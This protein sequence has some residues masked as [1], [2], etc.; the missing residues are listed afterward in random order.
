MLSVQMCSNV[1]VADFLREDML[2]TVELESFEIVH[3]NRTIEDALPL[4]FF[5]DSSQEKSLVPIYVRNVITGAEREVSSTDDNTDTPWQDDKLNVS[6]TGEQ[7][8]HV[9]RW[10][11]QHGKI[12]KDLLTESFHAPQDDV[13]VLISGPRKFVVDVCQP[14]V[15]EMGYK[16]VI[17]MW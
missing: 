17:A 1:S 13:L 15:S 5:E 14:L 16:N 11:V 9:P 12:D 3:A 6:S 2:R 7:L 8:D 4:T 10:T